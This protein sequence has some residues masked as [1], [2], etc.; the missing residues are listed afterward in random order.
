MPSRVRPGR[1]TPV[2]SRPARLQ[3]SC[4]ASQAGGSLCAAPGRERQHRW[5]DDPGRRERLAGS[6]GKDPGSLPHRGGRTGDAETAHLRAH[7]SHLSLVNGGAKM[8]RR[9]RVNPGYKARYT[10][11][12]LGR[13]HGPTALRRA[14]NRQHPQHCS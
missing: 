5:W 2:L 3:L 9:E 14:L 7:I 11:S 10:L 12:P 8:Q 13:E 4:P 6:A 1:K